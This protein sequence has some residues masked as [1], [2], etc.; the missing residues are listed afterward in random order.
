MYQESE[1]AIVSANM[2]SMVSDPSGAV[3][4]AVL[5]ALQAATGVSSITV[6]ATATATEVRGGGTSSSDS[7]DGSSGLSTVVIVVIAAIAAALLIGA[8]VAVW[9]FV[10]REKDETVQQPVSVSFVENLSDKATAAGS[11]VSSVDSSAQNAT[12]AG[13]VQTS[14]SGNPSLVIGELFRHAANVHVCAVPAVSDADGERGC[15]V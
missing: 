11:D 13:S 4:A 6:T 7:S 5:A 3:G 9:F 15:C 2:A 10:C 8:I 14:E 12:D 1:L